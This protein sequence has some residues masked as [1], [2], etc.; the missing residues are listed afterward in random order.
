MNQEL[1][2][3]PPNALEIA[4]KRI[5]GFN[6]ALGLR[7]IRVTPDEVVNELTVSEQHYQAYSIVHGGVYA[8]MIETACS[9]GAAMTVLSQGKTTVGLE[10]STSFLRAVRQGTLRCSASPAFIGKRSHVWEAKVQDDQKR[11]VATGRVRLVV[12][13]PGVKAGGIPLEFQEPA[14]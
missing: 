2:E 11:L 10:N 12:L 7:F 4:N 6:K 8:A 14:E 3:F 1:N 5:V 13:E 9:N